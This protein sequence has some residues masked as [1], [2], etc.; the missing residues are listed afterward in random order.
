MATVVVRCVVAQCFV[1]LLLER[2]ARVGEAAEGVVHVPPA[3]R[4][5]DRYLPGLRGVRERE[6]L[7]QVRGEH[8]GGEPVRAVVGEPHGLVEQLFARGLHPVDG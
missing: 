8:R 1:P 5:V 6:S 4:Q 2:R 7:S 3:G